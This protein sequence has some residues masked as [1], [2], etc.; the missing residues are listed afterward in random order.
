MGDSRRKPLR[1][2]PATETGA[3]GGL[4]ALVSSL[5]FGAGGMGPVRS[6]RTLSQINQEGGFDCPGCAWPDPESRSAAEFC[7]NGVKHVSHEATRRRVDPAFFARHAVPAL[8]EQADQWLE[9]QGRISQPVIKRAGSDHYQA[10]SWEEA[11]ARIARVLNGLDSPDQAIFYTSG[12]TS[13][14]AAFLYQLFVRSFGTNNLPDCSNMCHESSSTGLSRVIGVGKGTVSLAD[15]DRADLIL[16]LG[17]NPGSNHPRM[18]T[19]LQAA[20]RRGCRVVSINPL[21]ELGLVRFAHP[22]DPLAVLGRSTSIADRFL[23]V[24]VGGDLALLKG[25]MKEVLQL[26][27]RRPGK[28]LDWDFIRE[29][30]EGF[31]DLRA[32][33]EALSWEE[34]ESQSGVCRAEIREV[35]ELY[36]RAESVIACWAMGLTQ[37]R[38]GVANVRDVVNLLL[39]R[40]QIGRPGAGV[41][42]VRGHS[43]VQGDR[44]M[45]IWERP[46]PAFLDRLG[47]EFDFEPPTEHGLDT[48]GAIEAMR[49]GR[50][51]VFFSL[52]GN[53]AVATPDTATTQEA[54]RR[55]ELTVQVSTV[56]NRSHLVTGAEAI[57]LPC[58][59]RTE[60]DDQE[61][62]RQ[63]VTV[64]N[65]M[66]V[67]HRSTGHLP[68]ASEHLKS[69]PAIV[70]GLARA[71]L[72]ESSRIPWEGFAKDY[73][74]IRDRIA[75][76]IPGFDDMNE[77][78]RRDGGFV[79]PSGARSRD[80]ETETG[81][82]RF[83]VN[84]LPRIELEPGQLLM[85][86]IRSHDQ[87]NTTIYS[88]DDR[89]RGIHGDRR[90]VLLHG[91]EMEERGLTD[92]SAVDLT[93]HFE[94]QTRTVRGFRV[95]RYEIPC[96]CAA[97]YFPE[98]NA[99]VPVESFA[100]GSRTPAFKSVVISIAPSGGASAS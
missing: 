90:V 81:R 76:V 83:T 91:D 93:S 71:V 92:G 11:F 2:E 18:L 54:L 96:G 67:V 42:P 20:V 75:R 85:M 35:A 79:L 17:Q 46:T 26:E 33:L 31:A 95:V 61:G 94:G 29:K 10:L 77:R 23:Q 41:C 43:N 5:R 47:R 49:D 8:L 72:G 48:V 34:I 55:C 84:P 88:Q 12:R 45:G 97:T 44:T 21:K 82:A 98:A 19:T 13:N 64:E 62:G 63:F 50:A 73:D 6:L 22:K 74:R 58:L 39:L 53:F 100:E 57:I 66:S 60:R 28:V 52:G 86:T 27:A 69:E 36:A 59:G 56:L 4:G 3:A 89:Y 78:V 99:L 24:R 51:R 37:H 16:L 7:E 38:F 30:T 1:V 65:S 32:Q 9:A 14:E 87:F 25:L 70:A 15:F 40:G 80:F 68:P